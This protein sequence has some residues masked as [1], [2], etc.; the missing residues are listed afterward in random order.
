[1]SGVARAMR[2]I[3]CGTSSKAYVSIGGSR[4]V[5]R[6]TWDSVSAV[7]VIYCKAAFWRNNFEGGGGA[8]HTSPPLNTPLY[9]LREISTPTILICDWLHFALRYVVP[10]CCR[11]VQQFCPSLKET[12][13]MMRC[14][15]VTMTPNRCHGNRPLSNAVSSRRNTENPPFVVCEMRQ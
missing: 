10:L 13:K 8:A 7:L 1:M 15:N 5:Q 4:N 11:C 14:R 12:L 2:H 9:V 6:G 3:L